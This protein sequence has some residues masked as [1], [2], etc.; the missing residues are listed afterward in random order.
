MELGHP[1]VRS[2]S[3]TPEFTWVFSMSPFMSSIFSKA[4]YIE[5]DV[6]FRASVELDY[7]L[8]IVTFDYEHLKCKNLYIHVEQTLVLVSYM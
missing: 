5:A 7:L 8:N 4:E 2:Y 3:L 1:Y 6:T